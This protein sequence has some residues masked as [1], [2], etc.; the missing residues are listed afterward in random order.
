M[1]LVAVPPLHGM[2]TFAALQMDH[3]ASS[4]AI[5]IASACCMEGILD[6]D[7]YSDFDKE[8]I[9]GI[10]PNACWITSLDILFLCRLCVVQHLQLC[11]CLVDVLLVFCS[12]GGGALSSKLLPCC[13][14]CSFSQF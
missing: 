4:V 3:G 8:L 10:E 9:M 2:H 1:D 7:L 5:V 11:C 14:N 6:C 12:L 13:F